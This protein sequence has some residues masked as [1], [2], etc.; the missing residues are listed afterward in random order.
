VTPTRKTPKPILYVDVDGVLNRVGQTP[1]DTEPDTHIVLGGAG[2][3]SVRIAKGT[4]SRLKALAGP[5]G[6]FEGRWA[7]TW[8]QGAADQIGPI[9]GVGQKWKVV[10]LDGHP[11][12][13]T[14]KLPAILA[15]ARKRPFAWVEDDLGGDAH[16]AAEYRDESGIP[17][18][19]VQ[20]DP[21]VGLTEEQ[22]DALRAFAE[23]ANPCPNASASP[24][25]MSRIGTVTP[26]A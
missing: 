9:L 10:D 11:H 4:A 13:S 7:T 24:A 14:A 20:P 15:D 3:Y 19:L 1:A 21:A 6:P 26:P 22:A 18:L 17:T 8:G 23:A 12:A 2:P 16:Q 25:A 5:D